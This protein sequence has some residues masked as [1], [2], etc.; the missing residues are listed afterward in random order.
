MQPENSV[1]SIPTC[2][3][4]GDRSSLEVL[5]AG[6][7]QVAGALWRLI[8]TRVRLTLLRWLSIASCLPKGPQGYALGGDPTLYCVKAPRILIQANPE[9]MSEILEGEKK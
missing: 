1:D 3:S 8:A 6:F 9:S 7:V 2:S 4:W 5:S